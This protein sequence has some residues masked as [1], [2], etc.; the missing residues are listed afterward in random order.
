VLQK[1]VESYDPQ[2]RRYVEYDPIGLT[3]SFIKLEKPIES[4]IESF[5]GRFRGE[6]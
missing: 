1:A 5:N 6:C 2:T 3:P 4:G